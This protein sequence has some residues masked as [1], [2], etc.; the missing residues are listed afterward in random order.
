MLA[1]ITCHRLTAPVQKKSS[2]GR[3]IEPYSACHRLQHPA[4][5][6][7]S[8]C[9]GTVML[10]RFW[11]LVPFGGAFIVTVLVVLWQRHATV[12]VMTA[13]PVAAA[14]ALP[15]HI[16]SQPGPAD[17]SP[18]EALRPEITRRP[19]IEAAAAAAPEVYSTVDPNAPPEPLPLA[20]NPLPY[21]GHPGL[22]WVDVINFSKDPLTISVSLTNDV[23]GKSLQQ[24]LMLSSRTDAI[25][26]K[27]N[28]WE[29]ES[30]DILTV[31][32]PR[33]VDRV[34]KIS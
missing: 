24:E 5:L 19:A 1:I 18:A 30:G 14:I 29:I 31:T 8:N 6:G 11:A 2:C 27:D 22:H 23:T 32:S 28:D 26:G 4:D 34:L 15:E 7:A 16:A 21:R 12:G 13:P 25:L 3:V 17:A 33:F 9:L 20:I 10:N